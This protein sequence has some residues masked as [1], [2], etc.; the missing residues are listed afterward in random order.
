MTARSLGASRSSVFVAKSLLVAFF[1][2]FAF[3]LNAQDDPDRPRLRHQ[4]QPISQ[5]DLPT[6]L[7]GGPSANA[8]PATPIG[9]GLVLWSS[10]HVWAR[11]TFDRQP[12]LVQLRFLPTK[13][14][15]HTGSNFLKANLAP[16][17]YKPRMSIEV[18]GAAA[19][20]RLHDQHVIIY[21]RRFGDDSEDA[22]P[23]SDTSTQTDLMLVRAESR[24]DRRIISNVAFTQ[25]TAKAA[26]SSET[27]EFTMEKVGNTDW[28]K[29]TPNEPLPPGEY[30]LVYMPRGQNL[31]P[32]QVF[33][34]AV[35][36]NA[37]ANVSVV[38]PAED[39]QSR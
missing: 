34:F 12:Q 1:A 35:D 39:A 36:P 29:L 24:K 26:R 2:L 14:N 33:D 13:I 20:V 8:T 22:A 9:E 4:S 7:L 32:T 37:P 15:Q 3:G 38:T 30:A 23:S 17:V 31:L 28:Q 6:D 10:G 19:S 5:A 25:I 11:D 21:I 18:E 27:I 16:F